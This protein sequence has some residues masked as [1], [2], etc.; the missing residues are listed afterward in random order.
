[1]IDSYDN[2]T[3]YK[4]QLFICQCNKGWVNLAI[5]NSYNNKTH[6][7]N[8]NYLLCQYNLQTAIIDVNVTKVG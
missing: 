1:M 5:M 3:S 2:K 6:L 8:N 7:T 4:Q